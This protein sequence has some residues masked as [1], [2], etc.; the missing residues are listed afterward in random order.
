MQLDQF[1]H[2][3]EADSGSFDGAALGSGDPMESLENMRQLRFGN[4]GAGVPNRQFGMPS[5][6]AS[7]TR[8]RCP[9]KV[10]FKAFE[11]RL[12]TIFSHISRSM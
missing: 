7:A 11:S 10:N 9:S 12:R 3:R 6:T 4:A 5:G 8:S 1:L 2:Q